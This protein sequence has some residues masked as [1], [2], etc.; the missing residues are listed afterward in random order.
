[1][2]ES[3]GYSLADI[4]AVTD[5]DNMF[6]GN[7]GWFM[8]FILILFF[9]NG[10]N[11]GG[12]QNLIMDEFTK[13]DIFNTNQ[14]VSNTACET[15]KEVLESRYTTQLGLQQLQA[16]QAQCCCD[17]NRNIDSVRYD[18]L[19]NFKDMQ[20]QFAQCLNKFF[21]AKKNLFAKTNT[22]GTYA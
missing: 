5:N 14:N 9:C 4:K 17:T 20:A 13:R 10:G 22:V 19:L 7:G 6:G 11:F 21:R 8:W 1:M 3:T 15:Q 18:T 12:N 16:A 2:V